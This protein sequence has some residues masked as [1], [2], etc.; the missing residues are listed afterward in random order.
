MRFSL[1][2]LQEIFNTALSSKVLEDE[3]TRLGLEVDAIEVLEP[4]FMG[5]KVAEVLE[6]KP[7]PD[8]DRLV[9]AKVFDGTQELQVVCGANNCKK[10][11][12]TALAPIDSHFIDKEGKTHKIKKGKLRGVDSHGMLASAEEMGLEDKSEGIVELPS[13]LQVGEEL[14]PYFQDDVLDISFTPN[15]GHAMSV[16]GIARE[17]SCL[18]KKPF[19]FKKIPFK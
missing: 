19:T 6:V 15:L 14:T 9:V 1:N 12:I 13:D 18:L 3:L 2:W 16:L 11:L 5:L 8:A 17:L 10:G 4:S 7:H